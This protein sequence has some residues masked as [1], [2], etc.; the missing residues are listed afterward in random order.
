MKKIR[1]NWST[2]YFIV[3]ASSE[4]IVREAEERLKEIRS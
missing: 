3:K 2:F 1:I 4:K